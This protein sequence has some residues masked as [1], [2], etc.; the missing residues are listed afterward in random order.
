MT[1]ATNIADLHTIENMLVE[2]QSF[3]EAHYDADNPN[4]VCDR[5]AT[6]EAYMAIT[7]KY[8]ADAKY[9][10]NTRLKDDFVNAISKALEPNVPKGS[11]N[12]YVKSLCAN[13]RRIYEWAERLNKT[14]THQIELSRSMISKLKNEQYLTR[15]SQTT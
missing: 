15:N 14:C 4:A 11:I 8:F 1:K 13:E 6:L 2:I 10:Y 9:H 3:C 5:A 12:E 7:G